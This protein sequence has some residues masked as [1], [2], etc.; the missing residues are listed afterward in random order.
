MDNVRHPEIKSA[1]KEM[2][3]VLRPGGRLFFEDAVRITP[4][5]RPGSLIDFEWVFAR[6]VHF[7]EGRPPLIPLGFLIDYPSFKSRCMTA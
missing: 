1:L 4:R 3:R 6:F 5:R 2:R 7:G